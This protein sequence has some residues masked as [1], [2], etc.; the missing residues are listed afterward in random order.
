MWG[1]AVRG[2]EPCENLVG[3]FM[4][5]SP[6]ENVEYIWVNIWCM[7]DWIVGFC[8]KTEEIHFKYNWST[9]EECTRWDAVLADGDELCEN[10]NPLQGLTF[11][12][13]TYWKKDLYTWSRTVI[14]C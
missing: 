10:S 1:N 12:G 7:L 6:M 2:G 3:L 14:G 8:H 11:D 4:Y 13:T 5:H 9:S